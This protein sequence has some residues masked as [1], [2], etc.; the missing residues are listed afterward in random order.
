MIHLKHNLKCKLKNISIEST[1]VYIRKLIQKRGRG[2]EASKQHT[3]RISIPSSIRQQEGESGDLFLFFI[4]YF[5]FLFLTYETRASK[6]SDVNRQN[7]ENMDKVLDKL[8]LGD[9]KF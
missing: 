6:I 9:Y 5:L 8:T 4:S 7:H 1:F 2:G 3:C